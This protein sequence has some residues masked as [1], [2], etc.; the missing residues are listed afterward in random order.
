MK[1]HEVLARRRSV[2]RSSGWNF[3]SD[4]LSDPNPSVL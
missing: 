4:P 1:V 3:W 2:T